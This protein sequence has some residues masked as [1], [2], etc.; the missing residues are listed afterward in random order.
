MGKGQEQAIMDKRIGRMKFLFKWLFVLAGLYLLCAEL[1]K[2]LAIESKLECKAFESDWYM[3]DEHGIRNSV[4]IPGTV[5]AQ[6]DESVTISTV[7]PDW[8][9]TN[10]C[11]CF[12]SNHQDVKIYL[13]GEV[14]QTYSTADT[15]LFGKDSATIFVFYVI[16]EKDAGKIFSIETVSNS[17]YT[18]V[19]QEIFYGDRMGIWNY[20]VRLYG[21]EILVALLMLVLAVASIVGSILLRRKYHKQVEL[22]YLGW[23]ILIA[24][25]WIIANSNLRQLFF[26]NITAISNMAFFMVMLLPLPFLFYMNDIQKKRHLTAFYIAG[27]ICFANAFICIFLQIFDIM[28]FTD[29]VIAMALICMVVIALMGITMVEDIFTGNIKQ[30]KL[31]AIGMLGAFFTAVLQFVLYFKRTV[32]F[33]GSMIAV[34]LIF[35]LMIS[36][37]NTVHEVMVM[38]HEKQNAL[39]KSESKGQFLANMSH[40]IRTP[41]NAILGMDSMILRES[42]EKQIREYAAD[43][44]NSGQSLLALINDILDFSKIESGKL[45]IQ[46]VEYE[47]SSLISDSY[48]M[49]IMRAEDKGLRVDV[50]VSPD[51]P[52]RLVG[53]E[54]RIR[55]ILVNLLTNAV[56][57]THQGIV[58]LVVA[59]EVL[60]E[61]EILLDLRVIDTGIG[62]AKEN[63]GKLFTSFQR[64][65]EANNRNIE[66]TGLGLAITNLITRLMHGT[67]E[68]ESEL[69]KGS[70]FIVKVPQKIV[71][72]DKIGDFSIQKVY[73]N[74]EIVVEQEQFEAPNAKILVVDDVAMNLKVFKGLLK[75]T[76]MQ[77]DTASGGKEALEL[78]KQNSYHIIFL[79]H[80]MPEM[81][82]IETFRAMQNDTN[83]PNVNTP[84][85]MLTANAIQG[86]KDEYLAI[87]FNDYITKPIQIAKL[88]EM[89]IHYLPA[90]VLNAKEDAKKNKEVTKDMPLLERLTFLDTET[91]MEYCATEEIYGEALEVY[92]SNHKSSELQAAYD[93]KDWKQYQILV[94]SIKS[95]SLTIGAKTLSE[96][97]K[98]LE[99]A[100]KEGHTEVIQSEHEQFMANYHKL[101]EQI[102]MVI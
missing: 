17:S 23:S 33:N 34:G 15:R 43:I 50:K 78:I 89:L 99:M 29:T 44:Q 76:K 79:D 11:I 93:T 13:D 65:D 64:I 2:P 86:A 36:T 53:D 31:S 82:G 63:L 6:R 24:S 9:E 87:G 5:P 25:V 60:N 40:E 51:L 58:T 96:Q 83:H 4:D 84:V 67:I 12:H 94:H 8:I 14:V 101:L 27:C 7:L 68:V 70:T 35:L 39:I 97:A 102:K 32:S 98:K 57:Y 59:G 54:I 30:Y 72:T 48:N 95:S 73:E 26:S 91:G 20:F 22:E 55:Q 42:S 66:G 37:I 21:S 41:I 45:E 19:F 69:G 100:A 80:M 75:N 74:R 18:G 16:K 1:F 90:D 10:K 52:R 85:I 46:P 56:K 49:I 38:E 77:V 71:T 62:I 88:M 61:D 92:A 28:Q 47:M 81:D 3:L